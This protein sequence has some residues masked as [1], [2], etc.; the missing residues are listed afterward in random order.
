[1]RGKIAWYNSHLGYGFISAKGEERDLFFHHSSLEEKTIR[2]IRRRT[3][4]SFEK[5]QTSLGPEAIS[6]KII[7]K[8]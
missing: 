5:R 4:V 3:K 6:V 1:M 7:G 2:I 8:Q